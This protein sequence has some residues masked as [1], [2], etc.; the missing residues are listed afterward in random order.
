MHK[1][2]MGKGEGLPMRGIVPKMLEVNRFLEGRSASDP[3]LQDR[4]I[5]FHPELTWQRLTGASRLSCDRRRAG[6]H[7]GNLD[8][9]VLSRSWGASSATSKRQT[10]GAFSALIPLLKVVFATIS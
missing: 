5:E 4:I 10:Q 8:G 6:C 2:I 3:I 9:T 1:E 7:R